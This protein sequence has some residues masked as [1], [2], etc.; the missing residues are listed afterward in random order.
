MGWRRPRAAKRTPNVSGHC[1]GGLPAGQRLPSSSF[2]L[3]TSTLP[4][5]YNDLNIFIILFSRFMRINRKMNLEIDHH[6][7]QSN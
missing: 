7:A 2:I 4:G 6:R 1:P 3:L 5:R